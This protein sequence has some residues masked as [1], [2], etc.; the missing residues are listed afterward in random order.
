MT[1]P[2]Q[3][4]QVVVSR[5][6]LRVRHG[7]AEASA[8]A[9]CV[10]G[11][12]LGERRS[13]SAALSRTLALKHR[14]RVVAIGDGLRGF[15]CVGAGLAGAVVEEAVLDA[16]AVIVVAK[17]RDVGTCGFFIV[18][19]LGT[20]FPFIITKGDTERYINNALNWIIPFIADIYKEYMD[21]LIKT[22]TICIEKYV[23]IL[24]SSL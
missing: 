24:P 2:R 3:L 15:A 23:L 12:A 5:G 7:I 19:S 14:S 1:L 10:E 22:V 4:V 13:R 11:V 9:H 16:L 18:Y 17:T 21:K 20:T 8:V 6:A